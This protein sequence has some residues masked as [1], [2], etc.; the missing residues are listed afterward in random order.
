MG[1]KTKISLVIAASLVVIG[2]MAFGGAMTVLKWDFTKLSTVQY[3]T[4][5]YEI[6][7]DYKDISITTDTADV[8]FVP[9][10]NAKTLVVCHEQ[11]NVKHSVTVQDGTLVIAVQDM[12]K[13][14]EHIGVHFGTPTITVYLPNA[15]YGALSVQDSTG[16]V[17]I[18]KDFRF[19]RMDILVSTGSVTNFAS[20]AEEMHI[21][22]S[23]GNI[24]VENISAGALDLSVSTGKI[25][26][27]DVACRDDI[28]VKGTTGKANLTNVTCRNLNS[29]GSTGNMFL[30]NVRATGAFSISRSTG[31]VKFRG[32]D[33]AELLVK[34][35]TGNVTGTLLTDK[36]FITQSDT[37]SIDVPKTITGGKCEITTDTGNIK[38]TVEKTD[39][40]S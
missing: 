14:Y 29:K 13:W 3:E 19:A 22:T 35:D 24:C 23:T 8:V 39:G 21:K 31:N 4:N 30:E 16:S 15:E 5:D 10:E 17:K 7:E 27:C 40:A 20:A 34:T 26:V 11:N 1:R 18:P 2:S 12:R 36:V 6:S 28:T 9:S 38:I 33:A 25:T 37:G 32:C